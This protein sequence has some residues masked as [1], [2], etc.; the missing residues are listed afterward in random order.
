MDRSVLRTTA[1]VAVRVVPQSDPLVKAVIQPK[2]RKDEY[3]RSQ[4]VLLKT[5][6][7]SGHGA[8]VTLYQLL[9]R[10]SSLL[11]PN[12]ASLELSKS[13]LSTAPLGQSVGT[14]MIG[15]GP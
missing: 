4:L 7:S 11:T 3:H 9:S 13:Q 6:Q 1:K 12:Q 15:S 14:G 2:S 10:N 5:Q 8:R